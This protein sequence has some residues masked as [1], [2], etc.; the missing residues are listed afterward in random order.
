METDTEMIE[1]MIKEIEHF[2]KKNLK[3]FIIFIVLVILIIW[4]II[5]L[6]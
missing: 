4:L 1:R 6:F 3:Y 5:K 2:F